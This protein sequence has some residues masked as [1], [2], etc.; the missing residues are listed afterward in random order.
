MNNV[1][2]QIALLLIMCMLLV[3]GVVMFVQ[4]RK[5]DAW[6]EQELKKN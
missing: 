6:L 3:W 4:G 1:D 2:A 5:E